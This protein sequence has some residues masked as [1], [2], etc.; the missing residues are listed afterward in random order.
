M[1]RWTL[2]RWTLRPETAAWLIAGYGVLA[3]NIPFLRHLYTSVSPR[4]LYEWAFLLVVVFDLIALFA[5]FLGAFASRWLFKPVAA[6]MLLLAAMTSHPMLEYGIVFNA[7]MIRNMLETNGPEARDLVTPRSIGFVLAFAVVPIVLL[8]RLTISPR[9]FWS[10]L[11]FKAISCAALVA[12]MLIVTY[13]FIMN[14]T[15]VFREH[16]V[17]RLKLAPYSAIAGAVTHARRSVATNAIPIEP[18]GR[19]ARKIA[20]PTQAPLSSR[21]LVVVVVGE[22]ARAQNFSLLGYE[23]P[24][25][26]RLAAIP[27]LVAYSSSTSCGTATAY[28]VPCMF[29][30]IGRRDFDQYASARREGL[31]DVLKHAGVT[32]RWRDNQGGCKGV[33]ARVSTESV[34]DGPHKH[35]ELNDPLDEN[36]LSDLDPWIDG[37]TGDAVLVLHMMGSHGPAYYRRYP[38]NREIFKPACQDTQFSR[39]TR[40]LIVNAYDNTIAYTDHVLAELISLLARSDAKGRQT[41]MVYVSDHGESLGE[42]GIYLHGMPYALAPKE[43]TQVPMLAWF[44]PRFQRQSGLDLGCVMAGRSA[45][46]SHD[47]LFHTVLGLLDIET[48]TRTPGL[49]LFSACRRI[50]KSSASD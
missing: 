40:E 38:Q 43:Q 50:A 13:P 5:L 14:I 24:T 22:T 47:N 48:K 25:N 42:N 12:A 15:S 23:R 31:L 39:C 4:T 6:V 2:P 49:D 3:L 8:T 41:A 27:G 19:D 33:C 44:S 28:S 45:P 35:P 21:K 9:P 16:N 29:S 30:G 17:L 46:T 11:R 18:I 1:P 37:Q 34:V 10:E 36:L 20:T 26:P 7:E 32:V